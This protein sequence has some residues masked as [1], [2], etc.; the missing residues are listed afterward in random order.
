MRAREEVA[1]S[2]VA[3][4]SALSL[5][6][7]LGPFLL[8]SG[9][10]IRLSSPGPVVFRA[11]RMG[12]GGCMF[13]M[14]KLRTMTVG[15]HAG[16]LITGGAGDPRVF[17]VG[18]LL[19]AVKLD[20]VPQLVNVV[21]GEM[22]FVGPR[23]EATEIVRAHYEPW[24]WE[25]LTV[26]PGI[27]GPGSLGYFLEEGNLPCNPADA[28]RHYVEVLLPRKL[29]RDLVFIRRRTLRYRV[30]ILLRT[31]LGIVRLGRLA[32]HLQAVEAEAADAVLAS[33]L[34]GDKFRNPGAEP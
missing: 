23:P 24:M 29:A 34:E 16:G 32:G 5:L 17:R 1:V 31:F 2:W 20:E 27:V 8:L 21:R 13:V 22:A 12:R 7:L 25:T 28:E 11:E 3:R 30:E 33:V 15:A 19:R 26:P 9:L 14:Y 6:L 4:L 10:A 18:R